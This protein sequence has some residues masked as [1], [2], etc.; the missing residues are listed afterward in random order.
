MLALARGDTVQAAAASAGVSE[1]TAYRRAADAGF[2]RHIAQLRGELLARAA[3]KLADSAVAAA[4]ALHGLLHADSGTLQ[5]KAARAILELGDRLLETVE[6]E[7]R[8]AALE[9]IA[10]EQPR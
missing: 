1:R 3:G 8:V 4:E 10:E 5:L 6:M 9:R 2:R 7:A